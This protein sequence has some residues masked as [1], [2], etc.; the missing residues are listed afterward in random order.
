[1]IN[2]PKPRTEYWLCWSAFSARPTIL[3]QQPRVGLYDEV[4]HV[5]EVMTSRKLNL[6]RRK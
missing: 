6:G 2:T 1:M 4:I 3:N 5:R